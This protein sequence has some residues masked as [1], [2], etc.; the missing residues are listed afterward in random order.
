M[1]TPGTKYDHDLIRELR[2]VEKVVQED[3]IREFDNL[4]PE[5]ER[6]RAIG[7]ATLVA[8]T[9]DFEVLGRRGK[10]PDDYSAILFVRGPD[11]VQQRLVRVNGPHPAIHRNALSPRTRIPPETCHAHYMTQRYY[12]KSLERATIDPDGLAIATT[13]CSGLTTAFSV[14]ARRASII[15]VSPTLHTAREANRDLP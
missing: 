5:A 13:P 9:F 12:E 11:A 8:G 4:G 7:R 6:R 10:Y 3:W 1:T 2:Q 14:L 15:T